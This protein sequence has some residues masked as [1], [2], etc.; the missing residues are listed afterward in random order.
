MD[1]D[2]NPDPNPEFKAE[3]GYGINHSGT[4]KILVSIV[5]PD[6]HF[7][8]DSELFVTD[9]DPTKMKEQLNFKKDI[10]AILDAETNR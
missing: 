8:L 6:R 4:T 1:P 9:P 2:P 10:I 7:F 3:S 5:I